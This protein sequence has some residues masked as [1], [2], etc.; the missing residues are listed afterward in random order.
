MAMR[1]SQGNPAATGLSADDTAAAQAWHLLGC[2]KSI[3]APGMDRRPGIGDYCSNTIT[4]STHIASSGML[5]AIL[6]LPGL[7]LCW[8]SGPR[9]SRQQ[10]SFLPSRLDNRLQL[11]A[12]ITPPSPGLQQPEAPATPEPGVGNQRA[13]HSLP[14]RASPDD[15]SHLV[16]SPSHTDLILLL[17]HLCM[18][19]RQDATCGQSFFRLS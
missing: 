11:E 10:R 15:P 4:S 2:I 17:L 6:C 7:A 5:P 14:I 1:T 9:L 3:E 19:I 12:D 16:V 18:S 8:R 13:A